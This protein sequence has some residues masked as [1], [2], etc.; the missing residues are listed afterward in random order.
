NEDLKYKLNQELREIIKRNKI[1][2]LKITHDLHEAVNFSDKILYLGNQLN[3]H[4]K[5]SD[6]GTLNAPPEVI[7]YF[8]LG[9]L[10]E[11]KSSYY[12]IA[13]LQKD[14]LEVA[15]TFKILS[16]VKRGQVNEYT[17]SHKDQRLK[18]FSQNKY[19]DDITLY[20]SENDKII[21]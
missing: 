18:Y 1:I 15:F 21:L 19:V 14:A 13:C 3:V 4:F 8:Q 9:P 12:P 17:L 20:A 16:S 5:K 6:L 7:D 10:T 2:A 11:N